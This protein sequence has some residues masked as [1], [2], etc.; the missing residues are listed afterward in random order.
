MSISNFTI[1]PDTQN[2]QSNT[3][4]GLQNIS[5]GLSF[6][7][8]CLTSG[9]PDTVGFCIQG[10]VGGGLLTGPLDTM[11]LWIDDLHTTSDFNIRPELDLNLAPVTKIINVNDTLILD[12]TP[13][14]ERRITITPTSITVDDT[15]NEPFGDQINTVIT[16]NNILMKNGN[17]G[18]QLMSI[19]ALTVFLKDEDNYPTVAELTINSAS[20]TSTTGWSIDSVGGATFTNIIV[21]SISTVIPISQVGSTLSIDLS[22]YAIGESW[23]VTMLGAITILDLTNGITGGVYK[24]WL[25]VDAT[26]RT[27]TKACGVINNLAGDTVMGAGSIWLIEIFRRNVATYRARFTEFT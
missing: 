2:R 6:N 27:F 14:I 7:V 12:G 8:S 26:P 4:C 22:S 13:A 18:H 19:D 5:S 3:A 10:G 1:S 25:T 17:G 20:I 16:P 15:Q 11:R 24:I 23:D 9:D 21:D